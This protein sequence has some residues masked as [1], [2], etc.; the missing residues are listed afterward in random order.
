MLSGASSPAPPTLSVPTP[1]PP[2]KSQKPVPVP[3]LAMTEQPPVKP[4][5]K[6]PVQQK[7]SAVEMTPGKRLLVMTDG[8]E[9]KK[10]PGSVFP[11]ITKLRK[12]EEVNFVRRTNIEFN[13]KNWLVVKHKNRSGYIWEGVVQWAAELRADEQ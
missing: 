11:N 2:Q 3:Q 8:V 6:E 10:G 9:L 7:L 1:T 13:N 4:V 5:M 12:G